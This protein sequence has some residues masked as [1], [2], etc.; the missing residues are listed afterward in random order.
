MALQLQ[1]QH[2]PQLVGANQPMVPHTR[3]RDPVADM[4]DTLLG[5]WYQVLGVRYPGATTE[6]IK[7]AYEHLSVKLHPDKNAHHKEKAEGL[8]KQIGTIQTNREGK[9]RTARH[10]GPKTARRRHTK[11]GQTPTTGGTPLQ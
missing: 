8:F 6:E 9:G 3:G 5:N 11:R 1:P 2:K 10:R 4:P 7:R